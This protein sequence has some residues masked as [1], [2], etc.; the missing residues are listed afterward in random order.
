MLAAE[1]FIEV[2]ELFIP[3]IVRIFMKNN[4]IGYVQFTVTYMASFS[5]PLNE[6]YLILKL[7]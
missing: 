7:I 4:L 1:V 3:S 5:T 2:F 6:F